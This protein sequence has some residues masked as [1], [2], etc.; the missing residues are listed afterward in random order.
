MPTTP[1]KGLDPKMFKNL[2]RG[3]EV[4]TKDKEKQ[5][6]RE[7]EDSTVF[8]WKTTSPIVNRMNQNFRVAIKEKYASTVGQVFSETPFY[9]GKL[10]TNGVTR[11][12]FLHWGIYPID[13][14]CSVKDLFEAKDL[15]L[16]ELG[17]S[18]NDKNWGKKFPYELGELQLYQN[19]VGDYLIHLHMGKINPEEW[20][21]LWQFLMVGGHQEKRDSTFKIY[22][23]VY[24]RIMPTQTTPIQLGDPSADADADKIADIMI[25]CY[26]GDIGKPFAVK[27]IAKILHKYYEEDKKHQGEDGEDGEGDPSCPKCGAN[28]WEVEGV[29]ETDAN[30]NPTKIKVR[31]K[32]CGHTMDVKVNP[33]GSGALRP[34]KQAHGIKIKWSKEDIDKI[35]EASK[36]A[37]RN[38]LGD[39][40]IDLSKEDFVEAM[41]RA[42][43]RR[44]IKEHVVISKDKFMAEGELFRVSTDVW[45]MGDSLLDINLPATELASLGIDDLRMIPTV[46]LKKNVY[47][48]TK[49]T[50]YEKLKGVKYFGFLD[51]SGSMSGQPERKALAMLKEVWECSKKLDFD[52][53]LCL[54]STR[55]KRISKDEIKR[56]FDDTSFRQSCG[57]L[58]GGTC[59]S[60][61]FKQFDDA[62]Y[63]DANI[64]V[65][66]DCDIGDVAETKEEMLKIA[67]ST[68]SFKVIIIREA[69][70]INDEEIIKLQ[71]EWFPNKEV[72]VM[73]VSTN[74]DDFS[75][76]R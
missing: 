65:I 25:K 47:V 71:E 51:V 34:S 73:G 43:I 59:L 33:Y 10:F 9:R 36:G 17:I 72:K 5:V 39:I 50:D 7:F 23:A 20:R 28:D 55:A 76:E 11:H 15:L 31:C 53:H 37:D 40:G 54:F 29:L 61:G 3:I 70:R 60:E 63:K 30:G 62:E 8:V 68:N 58:G 44:F 67:Q 12:E 14:V 49:G 27:E 57:N 1:N 42:K 26:K 18:R 2:P 48:T 64:V 6:R 24:P 75:Y 56:F 21:V 46:T 19:M 16:F 69:E 45:Q 74:A 13:V 66:S 35:T 22:I 52:F 4:I 32:K 41:Q 38:D